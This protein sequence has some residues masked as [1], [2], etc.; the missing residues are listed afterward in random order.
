M[1]AWLVSKF[2]GIPRLNDCTSGFRCIDAKLLR[3]CDLSGLSTRG[4][5]FISSLLCELLW[6]GAKVIE[7]PIREAINWAHTQKALSHIGDQRSGK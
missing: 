3:S 2:G 1:A 5:S 4:Y 6:R 7:V